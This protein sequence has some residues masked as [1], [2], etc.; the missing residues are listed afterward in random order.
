MSLGDKIGT[1]V[2]SESERAAGPR[3]ALLVGSTALLVGLGLVG[4]RPSDPNDT[5]VIDIGSVLTL[6]ALFLIIGAIH[7]YG[8]LGPDEGEKGSR[9]G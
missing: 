8:R 3:R 5:S 9:G 6:L 1:L 4:L 2:Q 7:T